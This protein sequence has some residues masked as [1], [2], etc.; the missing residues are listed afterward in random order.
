MDTVWFHLAE[1]PGVVR[2]IETE[3]MVGA[4]GWERENGEL[5]FNGA[6]VSVWEYE[7]FWRQWWWLHNSVNV[8]NATQV[9]S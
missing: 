1:V 4:R 2:F 5:V 9:Y 6:I 3:R 8:F 7:K